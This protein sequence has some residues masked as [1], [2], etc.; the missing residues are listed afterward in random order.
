[1]S[2][3]IILGI[4]PGTNIMGYGLVIAEEKKILEVQF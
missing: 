4:D 3:K 1:M 2:S